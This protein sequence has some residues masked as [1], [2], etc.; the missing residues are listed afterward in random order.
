VYPLETGYPDTPKLA[1][2]RN[3]E[4]PITTAKDTV[5]TVST[6]TGTWTQPEQRGGESLYPYNHVWQTESG[7]AFEVDDTPDAERIHV[8]HKKGSFFEIQPD[9]TRITKIVGDDYEIVVGG[10]NVSITG[11]CNVTINGAATLLVAGDCDM[12]VE[13]THTIHN[14]VNIIGDLNISGTS[15]AEVD[16]ISNGVSGHDHTH[17]DSAGLGVGETTPPL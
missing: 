2:D 16:H 5:E 1:Y 10:K 17:M 14:T 11:D 4:D 12:K 8:Y 9:G 3:S 15:T 13:G 6:V 7:H